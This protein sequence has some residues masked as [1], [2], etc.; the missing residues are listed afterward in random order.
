MLIELTDLTLFGIDMYSAVAAF[1]AYRSLFSAYFFDEEAKH[2][3]GSEITEGEEPADCSR[4]RTPLKL[5]QT[6]SLHSEGPGP[7]L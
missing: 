4:Q 3:D 1:G 2:S 5:S 6:T 7:I